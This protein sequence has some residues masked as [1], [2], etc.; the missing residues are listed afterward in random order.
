MFLPP[1]STAGPLLAALKRIAEL[2]GPNDWHFHYYGPSADHVRDTAMRCGMADRVI[3]HGIVPR[4]E[5][6]EA[7]RGARAAAIVVCDGE[8]GG[9]G[10]KGIVP[11]KLFEP[12][13]LGTPVLLVGPPDGDAAAIVESTGV[14]R[15]L[16]GGDT[17]GMAQF[18]LS[19]SNGWTPGKVNTDAYSWPQIV[20][21]LDTVLR[22]AAF[23]N[24]VESS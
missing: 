22:A 16:R 17:E 23:P 7:I 19:L 8:T 5:A 9:P 18:L 6:L 13:G 14:G 3:V 20:H 15:T 1:V 10:I 11:G 21:T 2:S 24:R 12:M 4:R